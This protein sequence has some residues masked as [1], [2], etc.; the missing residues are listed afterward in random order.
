MILLTSAV[1]C[2]TGEVYR[3][4]PDARARIGYA[5]TKSYPGNA[6][7]ATQRVMTAALAQPRDNQLRILNLSDNAITTPTVWVNGAYLRQIPTLAPRGSQTVPYETLLQ[8]GNTANDFER[9]NQSVVKVELETG[10]GLFTV[11]GPSIEQ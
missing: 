11:L 9:A 3:V 2:S 6:K 10:E 1:G 4:D 8:A 5:A 7:A